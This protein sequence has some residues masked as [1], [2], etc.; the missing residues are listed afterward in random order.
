MA[1]LGKPTTTDV[2]EVDYMNLGL[3]RRMEDARCEEEEE[4][5]VEEEEEQRPL[6][7]W[8][9]VEEK[10]KVW[11]ATC[12]TYNFAGYEINIKESIDSY[13]AL[14]WPGAVAL[15]QYLENNTEHINLMDKAVLELGAGT[16]LVSIV[17]SLLGAWV[18]A[19]D[20]PHVLG[21]LRFNLTKN[22]RDRCRYTPQAAA[23]AWGHDLQRNFPRSA[24]KFEYVLA[25]DVVYNHDSLD[26][27]LETMEH[28]CHPRTTII[29]SNKLR[30]KSDLSFLEKFH[31]TFETTLLADL[32]EEEVK[33]FKA[34]FQM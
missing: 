19:A 20:L 5:E 21:N 26:E 25:A 14:I 27:L 15:C 6:M 22:T 17:A 12:E 2:R 3:V 28:F 34:T 9:I 10:K 23:M 31:N 1:Y 24:F 29:W 7:P 32:P 4:E 16:G 8:D 30:F 18:T 13:G 33:I 11:D